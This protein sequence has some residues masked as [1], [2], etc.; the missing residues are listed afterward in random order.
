MCGEHA[1]REAFHR[2][3][4]AFHGQE[5][6]ALTRRLDE[7][8]RRHGPKLRTPVIQRQISDVLRRLTR[9]GRL[10]QVRVGKGRYEARFV[11]VE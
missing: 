3:K 7:V 2:E 10:E 5:L 1:E 6:A 8:N 9:Q 4:R 11:R